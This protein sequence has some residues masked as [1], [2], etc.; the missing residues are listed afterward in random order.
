MYPTQTSMVPVQ[1]ALAR[2]FE[3]QGWRA[4]F[5][6]YPYWYLGTTPYRYLTGPILPTILTFIHK[7]LLRAS[8]F[9]VLVWTSSTIRAK[10]P[11]VNK[12]EGV[13]WVVIGEGRRGNEISFTI[14]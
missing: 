2:F 9:E 3:S 5:N 11:E 4:I 10:I 13:L 14:E 7:C 8:F 12:G 6:N 1:V